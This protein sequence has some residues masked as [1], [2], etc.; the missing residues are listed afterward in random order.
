MHTWDDA[1]LLAAYVSQRSEAA[2]AE[3]VERHLPLV[4]SSALRQVHNPHLAEEISQA[5][6]IILA[7]KADQLKKETVLA[8]WLCRTAHFSALNALK[9]EQRRQYHETEAHMET[10]TSESEPD[11]WP[12][13]APLLDAA[14]ARLDNTDRNAIV[15]RFYQQKSLAEVGQSLGVNPDAAQKRVTRAVDKLRQYLV[16]RG[17]MLTSTVIASAVA[18]NSVQAAPAGLAVTVT[19]AAAKGAAISA[20]LTTL[21][22]GTLKIMIYAKLKLAI[23]IAAG[24]LLVGGVTAVVISQA[25]ANDQWTPQKIAKKAQDT[26]AALSSY[27]DTGTAVSEGGGLTT[28]TTFNIRLQRPNLYRTDWTQMGGFYTGKGVVW[29]EGNG[30][31][32]VMGAAGQE[33]DAQPQKMNDMQQALASA[34][35]ASGQ[36]TTIPATFYQK[37]F[38]DV[39]GGPAKGGSQLKKANDERIGDVDCYVFSSVIDLSKLPNRGKLPDH[40]GKIGT[41]TTMFWI[42]KQDHLIH[43][44]QQTTEGMSVTFPLQSDDNLKTI[45]ER[46]NKLVTPEAIATLRTELEAANKK[47]QSSL[48]SGKF[49]FTQTHENIVINQ[50]F[51]PAD[52]AR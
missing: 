26:Y 16:K 29:S 1:D 9:A 38:G 20:T 2:F 27:S 14:L 3:L 22:K 51:S 35:G 5:V 37:N 24:I 19:A 10:L 33:K 52:F 47:A 32:M 36:A 28:T 11:V 30:D 45:L 41:I 46:Q 39:L 42:G 7:R 6:F 43:K 23:G 50:K 18:A 21:V 40:S 13:I 31:F 15:L 8:G 49:V 34:L 25:G 4:Y 17:V 48:K 44:I 12:Q